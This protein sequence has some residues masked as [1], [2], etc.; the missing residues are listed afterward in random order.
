LSDITYKLVILGAW[1]AVNGEAI[2]NTKPWTVQN[3]TLTESVWYTLS[4]NEKQLYASILEWPD[5]NTL[6]LGSVKLSKNS[7]IHLLGYSS[8][9]SVSVLLLSQYIIKIT[10]K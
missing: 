3:D 6:V 10:V 1:L 7:Q 2:Y 8:V 4:K 9:I 5:D